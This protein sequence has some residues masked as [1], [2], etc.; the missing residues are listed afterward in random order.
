M[1]KAILITSELRHFL[2]AGPG[3]KRQLHRCAV[4]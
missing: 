4:F 2:C 3:G 1:A